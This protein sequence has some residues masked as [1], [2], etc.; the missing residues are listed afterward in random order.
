MYNVWNGA[1]AQDF[2]LQQ[3]TSLLRM[4]NSAIIEE[5][6]EFFAKDSDY[7]FDFTFILRSRVWKEGDLQRNSA[8][9]WSLSTTTLLTKE[10]ETWPQLNIWLEE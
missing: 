8:N 6:T 10:P 3:A 1:C 2:Q 9:S 7:D 5:E 4:L